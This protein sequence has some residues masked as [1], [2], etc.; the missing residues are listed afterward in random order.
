MTNLVGDVPR[1]LPAVAVPLA[2]VDPRGAMLDALKAYVEG[3]E[4]LRPGPGG[5]RFRVKPENVIPEWPDAGFEFEYPSISF[6]PGAGEDETIGLTPIVDEGS[7]GVYAPGTAI[8][9]LAE[10]VERLQVTVW[11]ADRFERR[12]MLAGLRSAFTPTEGQGC[13]RLR[14]TKEYFERVAVFAWESV[15]VIDGEESVRGQRRADIYLDARI[16]VVRLMPFGPLRASAEVEMED[17]EGE[18]DPGVR[19]VAVGVEVVTE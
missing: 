18:E 10:Y 6:G 4:Y 15:E 7:F 11:A 17:P 12:A 2:T 14:T 13:V 3:I 19:I 9:Q 1:V 5:A 8:V 16:P